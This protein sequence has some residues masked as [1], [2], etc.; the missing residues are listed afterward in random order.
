MN[1]DPLI[2][3]Q[4]R[5]APDLVSLVALPREQHQVVRLCDGEGTRDCGAPI[6]DPFVIR[7]LHSRL[8]VIE[9]ALRVFRARIVAGE[10]HVIGLRLGDSAHLP[11][12]AAITVTTT[13]E[14]NDQ[15]SAGK[16]SYRCDR[17]TQRVWRVRVVAQ[18]RG[19]LQQSFETTK[20]L[21]RR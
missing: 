4:G 11:S 16:R 21:R 15:S 10:D 1:D 19:P 9:D 2:E 17:P 20:H 7:S 12:L 14:N 3:W 13:A 5:R 8:D 6:L 18:D